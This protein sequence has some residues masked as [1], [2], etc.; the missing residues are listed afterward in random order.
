MQWTATE[1]LLRETGNTPS[2]V[3]KAGN[4]YITYRL[5]LNFFRRN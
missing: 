5:I 3:F 1:N 2:I 4:V